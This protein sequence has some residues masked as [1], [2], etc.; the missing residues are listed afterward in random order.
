MKVGAATLSGGLPAEGIGDGPGG[1]NGGRTPGGL[2][3]SAQS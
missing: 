3:S 1:A 2:W